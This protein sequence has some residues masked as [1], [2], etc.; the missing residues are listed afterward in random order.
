MGTASPTGG[1]P[2][3]QPVMDKV[4]ELQQRERVKMG[5]DRAGS[6]TTHP[7]DRNVDWTD[8]KQIRTS[9]WMYGFK[10]AAKAQLKA[11]GLL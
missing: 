6:S 2:Y 3:D 8:P 4:A 9:R 1:P 7:E 10:T 11:T 5:F